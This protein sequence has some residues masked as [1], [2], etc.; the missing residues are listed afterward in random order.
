MI[1]KSSSPQRPDEKDGRPSASRSMT[2]AT[3]Y[4]RSPMLVFYELTRACDLVCLHCRACAQSQRDPGELGTD[5]AKRLIDQL[6][7]F[8]ELP[9]LVLTGGDPFKREDLFELIEYATN[10]GLSVSITPSATPL[11]TAEAVKRL[12]SLGV[13]RLAISMD[14]A[15]ANT[16]DAHRG[17]R[18]SFAHSLRILEGARES[19]LRTQVNT[20]MLPQNLG[21]IAGLADVCES[22]GI[23][24]WSVFFLVPVGRANQAPRLSPAQYEQAFACLY[25][26]SLHRPFLIKST[27]APHYRRYVLQQWR[28]KKRELGAVSPLPPFARSGINDGRGVLFVGHDGKILPSGFL[29]LTCGV[30]PRD[31]VVQVYQESPIF[32][33]L[34][35]PKQLLGKCGVCQFR[36]ICG[37]SRARSFAVTGDFL[38]AEPDCLYQ[39]TEEMET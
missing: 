23:D 32:L 2:P 9:M 27:E 18:G 6:S 19:G 3:D 5:Q 38:A 12:A 25:A 26:E 29:P 30:F 10:R 1:K 16:H 4:D 31:N 13:S 17:V 24:L 35:D 39:P 20:T 15:D 34:R 22:V 7:E 37:G 28:E 21:Q 14:G 36:K 8:P 33:A 11:V